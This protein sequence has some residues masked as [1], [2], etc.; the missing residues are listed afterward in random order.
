MN[1][2]FPRHFRVPT[3]FLALALSFALPASAQSP[4][5]GGDAGAA[6][7]S[8]QCMTAR[9]KE[10]REQRSLTSA[11][12]SLAKDRKGRES[13]SSKSMCAR[14][15]AAIAAME[16]REARHETRLAR[17]RE[18]VEKACKP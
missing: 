13:C 6:L 12:E 3:L 5:P 14:Y 9:K 8:K 1:R 18:D 4:A 16:K 2:D 17:F 11:S 15:D 10:E 7:P